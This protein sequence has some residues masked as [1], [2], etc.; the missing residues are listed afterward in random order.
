MRWAEN[1]RPRKD[2][3]G[4]VIEERTES[5]AEKEKMLEKESVSRGR[6]RLVVLYAA[7]YKK[8]GKIR[9][10]SSCLT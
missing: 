3:E 10:P 5:E 2:L 8:P 9:S 4:A 1:E 6:M 7:F